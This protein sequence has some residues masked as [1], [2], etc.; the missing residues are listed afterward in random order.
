MT[1]EKKTD[2][3]VSQ[4]L[5]KLGYVESLI[6]YQGS[7]ITKISD[8]LKKAS[9][10]CNGKPGKPEFI[11][12]LKETNDTI[13]VIEN[14]KTKL[15][16]ESDN[17][18]LNR[19]PLD[20][21]E[22]IKDIK[23]NAVD[24]VLHYAKFLKEEYNVIAIAVSG[25]KED[26]LL[27]SNFKW[28]KKSNSYSE[29]KSKE[30]LKPELYLK[31]FQ[32]KQQ[33]ISIEELHEIAEELNTKFRD[34]ADL[35]NKLKPIILSAILIALTSNTFK[36][37]YSQ[38]ET[39]SEL[40]N[41]LYNTVENIFITEGIPET[42]RIVMMAQ[43]NFI[44]THES[45]QKKG[46]LLGFI[47]EI[48]KKIFPHYNISNNLDIIGKFYGE[49]LRYGGGDGKSLGIVLTPR[50]ITEFF[51]EIAELSVNSKVVDPCCGTASFLISAMHYMFNLAKE[52]AGENTEKFEEMISK[53]KKH[54]LY[55]IESDAY[56]YTMACANMI[57]RGDGKSNIYNKS[58][59]DKEVLA[60]LKSKKIDVGLINPPYAKGKSKK[61]DAKKELNELNFVLN[62]LNI[63]KEDGIG[64]AIVPMSCAIGTGKMMTSLKKEIL[65]KHTLVAVMTMPS[66]L[67][68]P[69]STNTCIMVFR[70]HKAHSITN[71]ST[72]FA[73]LDDYFT[74][75]KNKRIDK[76][77][78]WTETK[79]EWIEMY[80]EQKEI[81]YVSTKMRV[82]EKQEW[83]AEDNL[84]TDYTLLK[85][86]HFLKEIKNFILYNLGK[87]EV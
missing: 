67:F 39:V 32:E 31:E 41:L 80:K 40:T 21:Q 19:T 34:D 54:N 86:K 75:S 20:I 50:H 28:E 29:L 79:K 58:C 23:N 3:K 53:I 55:G 6:E 72:W 87:N 17:I 52:S 56:M 66:Q 51:V 4:I 27:I 85:E 49:F 60:Q 16:H 9:K 63:L 14:K 48:Y 38:Q 42:K 11:V 70:A 61:G 68:H 84:E 10:N 69:V 45:L 26:D 24:G 7:D 8:L 64:I 33:E 37:T 57:L 2:F 83:L 65:E 5:E 44:K 47:D 22:K 35:D 18:K 36:S 73:R 76:S 82:D 62:M 30:I 43:Y 71:K 46:V 77:E 59:F 1:S 74:I 15:Q 12:S 25:T 81:K 78:T 13:L